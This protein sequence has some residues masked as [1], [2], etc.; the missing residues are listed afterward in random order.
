MNTRYSY[1]QFLDKVSYGTNHD[2]Y[3][4][5]ALYAQAWLETGGFTSNIWLTTNNMFGMRPAQKRQKFYSGIYVSSNGKFASYDDVE[6]SIYDR[7][8]LDTNFGNGGADLTSKATL[9][10]YMNDVF[11]DGYTHESHYVSA[12]RSTYDQLFGNVPLGSSDVLQVG[13]N[14]NGEEYNGNGGGNVNGS[15]ES[16]NGGGLNP[17]GGAD[18]DTGLSISDRIKAL[19]KALPLVLLAVGV[20]YFLVKKYKKR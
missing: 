20:G 11:E 12:W 14:S 18:L 2:H 6:D 15:D 7:L 3:Y 16:G 5:R 10:P 19:F 8:D 4:Y 1:Q 9:T 17:L 13:V